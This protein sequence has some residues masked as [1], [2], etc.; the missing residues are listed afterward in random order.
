M[1]VIHGTKK[2]LDRVPGSSSAIEA[3][4]RPL[5]SWYATVLF[6]KPQVTLL[7]DE[8]TYL[9][10]L[11]PLAPAATLLQRFPDALE[12]LLTAHH[13]PASLIEPAITAARQ[14]V[15]APTANRRAIGVMNELA[16]LATHHHAS[17]ETDLVTLAV[18][19]ARTPISPLYPTHVSPDRALTALAEPQ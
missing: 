2:L 12:R 7:V 5:G 4:T 18:D 17:G 16:Y 19:L 8:D 14:P 15:L 3:P 6:W 11:M 10:L 1:V 13:A 9:P